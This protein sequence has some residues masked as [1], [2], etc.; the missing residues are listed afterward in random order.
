MGIL[1]DATLLVAAA[2]LCAPEACAA[3]GPLGQPSDELAF[4]TTTSGFKIGN[5]IKIQPMSGGASSQISGAASLR[6][7][8]SGACIDGQV[9][10]TGIAEGRWC[11]SRRRARWPQPQAVIR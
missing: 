3:A 1:L 9:S 7:I 5:P 8:W 10:G 4:V 2:L 11:T 6:V